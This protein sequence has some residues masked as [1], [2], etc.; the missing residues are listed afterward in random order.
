MLE[1][2][3][4]SLMQKMHDQFAFNHSKVNKTIKLLRRNHHWSKMIRDVKQYVQNCYI[5]RRIKAA[6]NKYHELLNSLSMFDKSWIDITFDFVTKLFNN[7]NYNAVLMII[8]RLSK[9]HYYIFCT[10]DENK[11]TIEKTIKLLIQHVWKLHEL[12]ITMIFDR[13]SHFI[14]LVWNTIC[15]MFKI[16]TKLFTTFHSKTNEQSEIFNQKMKRYLRVYVNHQ[17]DDWAN[18]L[19]MTKYAFNAF[20]LIITQM[21]LFLI[22]Y[23]FESRM[24][25]DHVKFEK[26]T[27]KDRVNRFKERKIVFIMKNIWKFAKKH[28]KKNQQNQ[29]IYADKH[30]IST[31]NYQM[32]D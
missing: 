32:K 7:K 3:R 6:K 22:N 16:K 27:I 15:K 2:N 10:I 31:S 23:E 9:M 14:S 13:K 29:I 28:M 25:F 5:C 21:F 4:L 26:N 30:K 8:D 1:S 12:F 18:W 20:I 17:Q 19:F 11:T 24:S